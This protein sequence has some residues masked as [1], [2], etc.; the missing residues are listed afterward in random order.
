ME[1]TSKI[2]NRYFCAILYQEDPN[3]EKYIDSIYKNYTEV[4]YILHDK[5][6]TEDGELKKAHY[7]YLFRVGKNAR[8]IKA[9]A[10]ES[11]IPIQ[12]LER[13]K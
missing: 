10:N 5:D 3:F 11:E 2:K 12:Y 13:S 7:H 4:T 8:H 6:I 9:I 1:T